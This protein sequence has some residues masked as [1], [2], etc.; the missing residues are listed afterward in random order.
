MNVIG[1]A[2]KVEIGFQSLEVLLC[3]PRILVQPHTTQYISTPG[4]RIG[5]LLRKLIEES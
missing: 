2:I 4:M 5:L 1:E 3:V